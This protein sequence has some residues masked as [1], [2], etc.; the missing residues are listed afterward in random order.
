MTRVRSWTGWM[1][2]IIRHL[3]EIQKFI[4]DFIGK[5]PYMLTV[6]SVCVWICSKFIHVET[7][8]KEGHKYSKY[9]NQLAELDI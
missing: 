6:Q 3:N 7:E 4:A 5:L 1:Y 2:W 8:T 9:L